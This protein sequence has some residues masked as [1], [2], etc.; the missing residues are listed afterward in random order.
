MS[1]SAIS[2]LIAAGA[3]KAS[4]PALAE[5][6]TEIGL[7]IDFASLLAGQ[8]PAEDLPAP[9]LLTGMCAA[10]EDCQSLLGQIV[11]QASKA[12][13]A[14]SPVIAMQQVDEKVD[15]PLKV[16]IETGSPA[17]KGNAEEVL[18]ALSHSPQIPSTPSITE[19]NAKKERSEGKQTAEDATIDAGAMAQ[20]VVPA[21]AP[22]VQS[23]PV[24][25][26]EGHKDKRH[27]GTIEARDE[28]VT[29]GDRKSSEKQGTPGGA[30]FAAASSVKPNP[31]SPHA[32]TANAAI[33][34]G[35]TTSGNSDNSPAFAT[36]L[37]AST[38]AS[39]AAATNST[40]K[41]TQPP[42]VS[43]SLGSPVWSHDFGNR[44]IWMTKNDQQVAQININP[45]QLGP[46][47]V[48]ISLN[49]D[50]ASTVFAS[51][52]AEVR[53]A[54][55]DSLPQLREMFSAAGI[56]LGQANVGT[57]LP[58]QNREAAFQFANEARSSGET[59]ILPPDSHTSA[60]S[61][62]IPIQRGRGLVDLF[63]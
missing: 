21:I 62:G 24:T 32:E 28:L 58:S 1:I 10:G 26:A 23:R 48:S 41:S 36:A 13:A 6:P 15:K 38:A 14:N 2:N 39:G 3:G 27:E 17:I 54:I 4:L 30:P 22:P 51:P 55:Q 46:V 59:A 43:S 34:A 35:E 47:Q 7:P 31:V 25:Q 9:E 40:E 37:A 60:S 16:E 45:P 57:Q 5:I 8:I 19:P 44:V 63:A 50:Q 11:A 52:H 20:Y 33:L 53:Q 61:A 56:N 12:I 29:T 49:V 42:P 18:A